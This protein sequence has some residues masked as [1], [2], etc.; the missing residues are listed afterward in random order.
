MLTLLPGQR[1]EAPGILQ[2][3]WDQ[4]WLGESQS[5]SEGEPEL[6][7]CHQA[8]L[9][10]ASLKEWPEELLE[11][12]G[13]PAYLARLL[14]WTS[15]QKWMDSAPASQES[16]FRRQLERSSFH[17]GWLE[18]RQHHYLP[19]QAWF[20]REK[21]R[22]VGFQGGDP[23]PW[24]ERSLQLAGA[25]GQV[26]EVARC[27]AFLSDSHAAPGGSL[28]AEQRLQLQ[29]LLA[30]VPAMVEAIRSEDLRRLLLTT[31]LELVPMEAALWLENRE[32]WEVLDWWPREAHPRYSASLVED[33]WR[34]QELR[35]GQPEQLRASRS[36][37]LSEVH[38]L[39]AV[40]VGSGGSCSP[41]IQPNRP[42][43]PAGKWRPFSFWPGW[44]PL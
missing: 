21:A 7:L 5:P 12:E 8:L 18:A 29:P 26:A 22:L 41:G 15:L 38:G 4:L 6:L 1:P 40:P 34:S 24:L 30:G 39:L 11:G 43:S 9:D 31:V 36:I 32:Q 37:L 28:D 44:P 16:E 33:C 2:A 17:C 42:G 10:P 23:L 20:L 14:A 25:L 19:L 35:W 3:L 13:F 27:R